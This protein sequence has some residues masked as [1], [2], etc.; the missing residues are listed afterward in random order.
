MP[1]LTAAAADP[2]AAPCSCCCFNSQRGV[3]AARSAADDTPWLNSRWSSAAKWP[4]VL[5]EA[6]GR[7]A[8]NG[9]QQLA[10][11]APGWRRKR[12]CCCCCSRL[13]ADAADASCKKGT[14]YGW[15]ENGRG[16]SNGV[17]RRC[18]W[19]RQERCPKADQGAAVLDTQHTQHPTI[20]LTI[21][22]S[23]GLWVGS[24]AAIHDCSYYFD[25]CSR[26]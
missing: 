24:S 5:Q 22:K 15:R 9:V 1:A 6:D 17:L 13:P 11:N 14:R 12:G 2:G 21:T 25:S 16:V 23:A 18:A 3:C 7:R 8:S 20:L 26:L 19:G 4:H 10:Q